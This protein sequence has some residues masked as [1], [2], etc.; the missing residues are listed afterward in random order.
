MTPGKKIEARRETKLNREWMTPRKSMR[1]EYQHRNKVVRKRCKRD[2]KAHTEQLASEAEVAAKQHN[3]KE[4][5]K[6][7]RKLAWEEQEPKPLHQRQTWKPS[8]QTIPTTGMLES[9]LRGKPKQA[10]T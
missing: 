8:Y 1:Q 4:L 7:T 3:S 2:K 5:Y 10:S 9:T 6:I